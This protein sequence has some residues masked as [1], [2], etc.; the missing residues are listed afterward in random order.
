M[1][2]FRYEAIKRQIERGGV[3]AIFYNRLPCNTSTYVVT[4]EERTFPILNTSGTTVNRFT[5][6]GETNVIGRTVDWGLDDTSVQRNTFV[7]ASGTSQ[8][9]MYVSGTDF[10]LYPDSGEVVRVSG[11]SISYGATVYCTYN[12]ERPCIDESTGGPNKSCP[13][14]SGTGGFWGSGTHITG[15]FHIPRYDSPLTKLGYFE[16]GDMQFTYPYEYQIDVNSSGDDSLYL[17]D[18]LV[19]NGEEW[20][21]MSKPETIQMANEYFVKKLHCRR[22][23]TSPGT[24][25]IS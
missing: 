10:N 14:C 19:I 1:G 17:R 22:F 16:T 15:L 4:D 25:T 23:K 20:R 9:R 2:S 13:Q 6:Y 21:V 7:L 24:E 11:S 8:A 3:D 12:W 5:L 18:R